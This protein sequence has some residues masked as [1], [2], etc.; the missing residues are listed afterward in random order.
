LHVQQS[1][2]T[3]RALDIRQKRQEALQL[4]AATG[5]WRSNYQP[6][7]LRL[8]WALGIDI[9]PPHFARFLPNV[10]SS[11]IFFGATWAILLYLLHGWPEGTSW[12]IALKKAGISG[13][14]FGIAMASYYAHGKRK[15]H[16]PD[17][18][19]FPTQSKLAQ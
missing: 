11:G 4:L 13:A 18:K 6:P 7:M 2:T 17:W 15:Y 12:L 14:L 9:P 10:I 1:L 5:M 19:N 3:G 8:L 16:L